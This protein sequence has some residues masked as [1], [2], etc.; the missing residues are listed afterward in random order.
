MFSNR[1]LGTVVFIGSLVSVCFGQVKDYYAV[2]D[3]QSTGI[4]K[5]EALSLCNLLRAELVSTGKI[6]LVERGAMQ[7]IL[8]EQD[9]QLSGCT[10]TECAT[11]IG[12]LRVFPKSLPDL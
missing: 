7:Q 8:A 12:Q 5:N 6:N 1:F 10:S 9:F 11:E 3:F 2:L 4:S